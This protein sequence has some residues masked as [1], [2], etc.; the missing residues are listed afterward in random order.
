VSSEQSSKKIDIKRL[1]FKPLDPLMDRAAFCCGEEELDIFFQKYACEHHDRYWA[2]VTVAFYEGELVGFYWL[3]AQSR[4]LGSI[5]AED[6]EKLDRIEF[7]PCIYLGMIGTL[8]TLQGNGIGKAMMLHAFDKTAEIA[9]HA[10]VYALTLEAI[11]DEKAATYRRWGFTTFADGG[12]RMFIPLATIQ[13]A[14]AA[15]SR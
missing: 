2:R 6:V 1:V 4:P 8:Q 14:L 11:N 7:A 12:M 15:L 5:S 9:E 10:G 13:A 3:V